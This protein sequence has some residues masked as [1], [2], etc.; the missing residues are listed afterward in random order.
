MEISLH[1]QNIMCVS[2]GYLMLHFHIIFVAF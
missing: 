1:Y 2:Y